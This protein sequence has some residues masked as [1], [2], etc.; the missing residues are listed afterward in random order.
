MVGIIMMVD[1]DNQAEM[2]GLAGFNPGQDVFDHDCR[3]G[4]D[5]DMAD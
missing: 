2:P 4:F 5:T 3:T 1:A